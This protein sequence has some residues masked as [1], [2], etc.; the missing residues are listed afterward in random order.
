M[1]VACGY[2]FT[3]VVRE[4]GDLCAFG[5]GYLGQLGLGTNADELLPACVGGADEVFDGEAV[6][7]VAAGYE[8]TAC[9]TAKGTV[10][11]WG[12]GHRG[13][14]GHGD[15]EPRQRP[16]RI[17]KEMF[18]GSPAVMVACGSNHTLVLTAL[19]CVWSCGCGLF[20]QLGHGDMADQLVLT[21]VAE[22][23]LRGA[24]IVMVAAGGLHSV[25]VGVEGRVWTWGY[26]E[27]GQ[28]GQNDEEHRLVPTLLVGEAF[29]GAAAVQVSAGWR[30]TVAVTIEGALWVWGDGEYGQLGL[31]DKANRL[32]PMLV[33]AQVA[34]G[35]SEVVTVSCGSFHTLAVTKDG[36]LHTFGKGAHGAL[37][38]NDR[39]NR[40][41]PTRIEPLHFANAHIV[42]AAA[43]TRHSTAVT[44]E[45][46][47]YTWGEAEGLGHADEQTKFVPTRIAARLL[48]GARIGRCHHL[49]PTHALAFA[50]GTHSRLGRSSAA[51]TG[52]G[53]GD[54]RQRRSERQGDNGLDAA[55][56]GLDAPGL[57]A[58]DKGKDCKCVTMPDELVQRVV[59]ACA[60]WPEGR[61]GE[62][63][64]VVR[65][66]GG[67][68]MKVR[69]S[70]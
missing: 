41:V 30:H 46:F 22:E 49:P 21:L 15:R 1:S 54:S 44:K 35:G 66:L 25:A 33:G 27:D 23:R 5:K 24:L 43:G 26:G 29:G 47:L 4:Q 32:A 42:S 39:H 9:V 17:G 68:M 31:G 12:F 10:W 16:A 20:G 45:G 3:A 13:R 11:S 63:E 19:G 58:A 56:K 18:G 52:A 62:L 48:D 2:G 55:D 8:H 60:S 59:E 50:M 28:L 53:A 69:G 64:G 38:H 65:L 7:M 6:V 14:L 36:A 57:D 67:G 40:L 37:G 34:F 61:A 70:R 51:A